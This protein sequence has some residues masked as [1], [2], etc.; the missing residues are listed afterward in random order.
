[1]IIPEMATIAIIILLLDLSHKVFRIHSVPLSWTGV[2]RYELT[3]LPILAI[4]FLFFNPVS[5]SI[6]YL[7]VEFPAYNFDFYW[8]HYI[9][10]TFTIRV[11]FMYLILVLLSGYLS[12]NA[13]LLNDFIK[14]ARIWKYQNPAAS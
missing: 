4:S 8:N 1:M 9:V 10:G 12:L 7:L 3:F 14:S 2:L 11:Y 13:S 6:R 5:Q